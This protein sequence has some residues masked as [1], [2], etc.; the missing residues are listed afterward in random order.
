MQ[1][2]G[3]NVAQ[4]SEMRE[5]TGGNEKEGVTDQECLVAIDLV[6]TEA[7]LQLGYE[8]M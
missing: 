8:S 2:D 7:G 5:G 3:R 4:G 6:V 1:N